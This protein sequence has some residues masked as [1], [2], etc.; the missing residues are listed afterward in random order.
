MTPGTLYVV[1]TPIGNLDDITLR[2]L[3]VLKQVDLIACEDTRHSRKLLDHY[4][5]HTPLVS[6]HEHNEAERAQE[7]IAKL[8][9]GASV[10]LISDAGT[11]LISDPGYR[12]VQAAAAAGI[13][14]TP[15]PGPSAAVAALSASGLPTDSFRFCGFLPVKA[16]QRVRLLSSLAS[17]PATL[18][19]Y[20]APH[21]IFE[22]LGDVLK[23]LGNRR[24]VIARELTKMHEEFIRG[25]VQEAIASLRARPAV[26]GELTVL[27]AKA[28]EPAASSEPV[29]QAVAR[30]ER[31]GVGRME[32][33]K[34][35]ARERGISKRDVYREMSEPSREGKEPSL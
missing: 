20:E 5:I 31:E 19:V 3:A 2:A 27:I 29:R 30:L 10:A 6:Y 16:S 15:I 4:G 7:L 22:T 28:D 23:T 24:I 26:K 21:R 32:A 17:D 14:V 9:G 13:A 18:I 34:R 8:R 12:L 33:M 25:T 35:V 1:A 11:P